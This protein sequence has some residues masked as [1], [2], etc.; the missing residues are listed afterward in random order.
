MTE[1]EWL[2]CIDPAPMIRWLELGRIGSLRQARLFGVACCW[3]TCRFHSDERIRRIVEVA[4]RYADGLADAAE[5]RAAHRRSNTLCGKLK[6]TPDC[7]S[8]THVLANAAVAANWVSASNTR[9]RT[10]VRDNSLMPGGYHAAAAGYIAGAATDVA[11]YATQEG[12]NVA[13][14]VRRK[15]IVLGSTP[16]G[17]IHSAEEAAQSALLRCVFGNPFRPVTFDLRWR[18][19]DVVGLAR[20]IYDEK[21][22]ERLPILAD[23]LMDA[24]CE[25][26]Q[27]ISHCRGDGPHVRGCWVVDLALGKE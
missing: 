3:R 4:E 14:L 27:I 7:P 19:F 12:A 22:F 25:D 2:A 23:A 20:A 1:V 21:E 11:F 5:L 6:P 16:A 9:F 24:G 15:G 8:N 10:D 13:E 17:P 26:E 18:T